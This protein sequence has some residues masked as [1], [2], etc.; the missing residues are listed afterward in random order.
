MLVRADLF[1]ELGG[2]DP[3]TFPGAEDLD[4]CWRRASPVHALG[5]LA[6]ATGART[7]ARPGRRSRRRGAT[8][9]APGAAEVG[10][11]WSLRLVPIALVLAVVEVVAFVPHPPP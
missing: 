1:A 11:G 5:Y 9:P 8:Q 2:F 6:R 4:L 3:R 10:V 7:D